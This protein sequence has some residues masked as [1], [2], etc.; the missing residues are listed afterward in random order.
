M[1]FK[2]PRMYKNKEK[3]K[4]NNS[5]KIWGAR[6]RVGTEPIELGLKPTVG[7]ASVRSSTLWEPK[8][9]GVIDTRYLGIWR[10]RWG[11]FK[12]DYKITK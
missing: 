5:K 11:L 2:K 7:R 1:T 6:L 9:S 4:G 10:Q 12:R 8:G 3:G